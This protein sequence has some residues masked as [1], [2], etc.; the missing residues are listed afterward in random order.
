MGRQI[1]GTTIPRTSSGGSVRYSPVNVRNLDLTKGFSLNPPTKR[2]DVT[3]GFTLNRSGRAGQSRPPSTPEPVA[4]KPSVNWADF[5]SGLLGGNKPDKKAVTRQTGMDTVPVQ[6]RQYSPFGYGAQPPARPEQLFGSPVIYYGGGQPN[7][8]QNADAMRWQGLYDRFNY[9]SGFDPMAAY[10]RMQP[11]S[12]VWNDIYTGRANPEPD[13]ETVYY[14]GGYGG[15]WGGWGG[16][17]G[18]KSP[19]DFFFNRMNWRI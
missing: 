18:Y 7:R 17:G 5:F 10:N 1:E 11:W 15:G 14:G 19:F 13:P 16:Y 3:Q 12:D 9:R 2:V 4:P 6:Y 8:G